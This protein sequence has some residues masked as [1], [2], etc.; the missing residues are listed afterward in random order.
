VTFCFALS[1]PWQA[2]ADYVGPA[3]VAKADHHLWGAAINTP[4]GFDLASR[5]SL[6]V[7]VSALQ[8]MQKLSDEEM[9]AAFK[10]KS[11]NR[12]SVEKWVSKERALSLLNYQRASKDCLAS[13]WTCVGYVSTTEDLLRNAVEANLKTPK[14]FQAWR[15]NLSSFSR[16]YVAEQLRLAALFPKVSSEIDLFNNSE[17]NGDSL[18]DKQ[19][20]L[21]FDDGPTGVH[22]TS[23]ET[24]AMLEME[25]K[26]AVF[27]VLGEHFQSRLSKTDAATL[28]AL[29]KNQCVAL[30]GWEHQSHAKWDQW[31]DSIK[32]TQAL[33]NVTLPKNDVVPLFRPPYGQR[34]DDSGT[35]FKS[36]SL[37]VVLWNLDSQDWNSHVDINDVTNRMITLM[38]I[39]RHGVLLFH[40][41][42]PKAKIA[43]PKIFE[44]LGN[45][46]EWG[47]CHQLELM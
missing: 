3:V 12:V 42:H 9:L 38:L 35:F 10:I 8:D 23:D 33:L 15:D 14:E 41:V 46:V 6:L 29:Y 5:A 20:F 36:Q 17:M 22:G 27:F 45:V 43:L 2:V 30:H 4:A 16:S 18:A 37:R 31:Q 25:N 19:F 28:T 21:S 39:K 47:D 26:S 7:Y 34:K 44:E 32:R 1:I 11:I 24:L 40:D 13:D